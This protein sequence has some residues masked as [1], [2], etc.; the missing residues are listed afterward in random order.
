MIRLDDIMDAMDG[1]EGIL[2]FFDSGWKLS[3]AYLHTIPDP[4][5]TRYDNR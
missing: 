1:P 5:L 3:V 2:F 4:L